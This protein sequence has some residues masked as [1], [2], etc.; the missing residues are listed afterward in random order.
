MGFCKNMSDSTKIFSAPKKTMWIWGIGAISD[1]LMIQMFGLVFPIFNTG[2]GLDSV[3]LSWA[4]MLPRLTDAIIDP[5]LGHFSDNLRTRW[6]RRKPILLVTSILGALLV[7]GIW[8]VS[9][10]WPKYLQFIY[11]ISFSVCYYCTWGTYSMSHTALG[12]E[13][14]DDYHER[15][16]LIAI[17]SIY[18]QIVVLVISYTYWMAL[19]P[20]F[21]GEINGIRIISGIFAV[22]IV[23]CTI[24]VLLKTKERFSHPSPRHSGVFKALLEALKLRPFRIFV[25]MRFFS[26]FGAVIFSQ[27]CFYLNVYYVCGGN[28]AMA[29]KIIGWSTTLTAVLAF[30]MMPLVPA[31]SRKFGKRQGF[32]VSAGLSVF[33]AA[34]MPF[35]FTP[36]YPYLQI[37]AAAL[38]APIIM[39]GGI[40]REAIVPDI[41]DLDEV[42]N[43]K[44]RE[45]LITAAIA[46]VYKMEVSLCVLVVGYMIAW[47]NFIPQATTQASDVVNRLQWCT[48]APNILCAALAFYFALKF[49]LTE[50]DV[51][52]N[53]AILSA[54]RKAKEEIQ[55]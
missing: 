52:E 12:Y 9:P 19:N 27:M 7:A 8:W 43:G 49:P 45:G 47:T 54:R 4:I 42:V 46:F 1:S 10:A 30:S 21:G 28:K 34:I 13:L 38:I 11:L 29:T 55:C 18:L 24:P 39:I 22:F 16:R 50:A 3:M 6:G 23:A 35:V 5:T 36:D 44:R 33:Q 26:A 25:L 15:T 17:R 37:F 32:V 14:T 2:F 41:C 53:S 48:F 40:L 51:A 31:I 20:I